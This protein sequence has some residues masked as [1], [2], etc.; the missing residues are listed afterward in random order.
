[1]STE[2]ALNE[3][4]K[5]ELSQRWPE[6]FRESLTAPTATFPEIFNGLCSD[7]AFKIVHAK[8]EFRSFTRS[9]DNLGYLKNLG[10]PWIRPR[11]LFSKI[12]HG[13]LF[14]WTLLLFLPN[15]KSWDNS[16]WSFGCGGN[17]NPGEG[18]TV[19]G[20]RWYRSKERRWVPIGL[21]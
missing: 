10:S 12:F 21:P 16:D 17:P 15:L 1:M 11:F 3:N 4:K 9:W 6:S 2:N 19:G 13:L 7:W 8:F 5:A 20:R 18:E 14:G